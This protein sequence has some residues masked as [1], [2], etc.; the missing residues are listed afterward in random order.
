MKVG[1]GGL[2]WVAGLGRPG[3]RPDSRRCLA[4]LRLDAIRAAQAGLI[5][6]MDQR[7][8]RALRPHLTAPTR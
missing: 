3:P 7:R 1:R 6:D 5:A 4:T 8:R 2:R